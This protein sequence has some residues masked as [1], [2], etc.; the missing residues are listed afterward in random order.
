MEIPE[1]V[2]SR[3][4]A[5]ALPTRRGDALLLH[6]RT[7]HSSL[8]NVSDKI[9]WSFDLRYN[10]TG[11]HTGR[12]AFPGFVARSRRNPDTELRDRDE[13]SRRWH[14][15]RAELAAVAYSAPFN[16]WSAHTPGCA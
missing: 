4:G 14:R 12:G 5:V 10:P 7:I 1:H 2:A 16:R 9:R 3:R 6:K 13:W 15:T 8:S 11:Q